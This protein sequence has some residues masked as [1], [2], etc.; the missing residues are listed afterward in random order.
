M[1]DRFTPTKDD[2]FS[3]GLWTVGWQGVDVFGGAVRPRLDPV[4]AVHRLAELGASAVTFHDDDL[5]P[6]DATRQA[7]LDRFTKALAETGMG[8]EMATTNLFS[9]AVFKDGGLTANDRD[10]RRYALAKVL[11]N[12]DL[13][14]ELG[15]KTYV[16]WGGREGA[17]SGGSKA[18]HCALD[19]YKES[20]DL[21]CRYVRDN[22]YDI[23]FALEPKPNEPRGDILLP[24]VG[25]AIA[26]INELE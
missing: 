14:A 22:G 23:R 10:V 7:E 2:K 26:F 25:H 6:D 12:I 20:M 21:L 1:T 8:V 17:E 9:H 24:T 13:A 3:F 18:V 15:A 5:V 4:E 16:L 11:R 19:R